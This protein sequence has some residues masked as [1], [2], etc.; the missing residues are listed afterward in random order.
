MTRADRRTPLPARLGVGVLVSVLATLLVAGGSI[1][2]AAAVG[3]WRIGATA[4][5]AAPSPSPTDPVSP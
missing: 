4:S 5:V 1:V 3:A 2:A